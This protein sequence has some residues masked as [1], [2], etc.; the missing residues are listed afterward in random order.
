MIPIDQ[1]DINSFLPFI[2]WKALNRYLVINFL[3]W[4]QSGVS[5]GVRNSSYSAWIFYAVEGRGLLV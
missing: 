4:C 1:R 3:G 5:L 2:A